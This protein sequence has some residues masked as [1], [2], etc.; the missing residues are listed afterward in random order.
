MCGI[1]GCVN[2]NGSQLDPLDFKK[3]LDFL[4]HRGP[5][6]EGIE[7][8]HFKKSKVTFGHKR[9]SIIDLSQGGH[10]P[11][12]DQEERFVIIFN[13]EIYNYIELKKELQALGHN[14]KTSSDTEVLL[15]SWRHWGKECINKL[16]G[17]F[18]FAI[19]DKREEILTLVRDAF[20]IKPLY[21]S[22][23]DDKFVFS[24]EISAL[25]YIHKKNFHLN[26][27][28]AYDFL[29][30]SDYDSSTETFYSEISQIS[31]GHLMSIHVPSF[32]KKV[33]RWH[34]FEISEFDPSISFDQAENALRNKFLD[35][36]KIH[37]RSDVKVGA[38]LSGGLDSSAIVCAMR[39]IEPDMEINTFSFIS[40]DKK[41]SEEYWVD[42]VNKKVNANSFKINL[43]S[44]DFFC[45]FDDLVDTLGE[46]FR[47]LSIYAQY[48]VFEIAKKNSVKVMLDG[49]GADEMLA[50]YH[51]Y[52]AKRFRSL[53]DGGDF[54]NAYKFYKDWSNW[55]N[56]NKLDFIKTIIGEFSGSLYP[57]FKRMNGESLFPSWMNKK[58]ISHQNFDFRYP[59]QKRSKGIYKRRLVSRLKEAL[60]K[61]GLP[62]LLKHE[63]RN[64]MRYSLESRVPFC[65]IELASFL[66]SLPEN[67]LLSDS[68]ETK[69]IFRKSMTNIVPNE[70]LNRRDKI[71]FKAQDEKWM[72]KILNSNIDYLDIYSDIDWLDK[73]EILSIINKYKDGKISYSD[74]IFRFISFAKWYHLNF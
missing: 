28:R 54:R 70:I 18:S 56:R 14:F 73:D 62:A 6:D 9:L 10:Q 3:S 74:Q 7:S 59:E 37:L 34:E 44:N 45:D 60:T 72:T 23:Q 47:T 26:D 13:G 64:S 21:H 11:M 24:S 29:V 65:N 51:G 27:S 17:M 16:N 63:D 4:K 22:F 49:Q 67:F 32:S 48:K 69:H 31:P 66:L 8:Y 38:A 39:H 46:P 53:L 2:I 33:E 40:E 25:K 12:T 68:G 61:D 42:M 5:D 57:I 30:H 41:F 58:E 35:S 52:P 50:G 55:P 43:D 20:G 15:N 71:G 36:V 19:L 1:L